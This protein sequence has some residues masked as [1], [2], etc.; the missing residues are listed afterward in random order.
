[1]LLVFLL[2]F[3]LSFMLLPESGFPSLVLSGERVLPLN[4]SMQEIPLSFSF[5]V[6]E[7]PD[8]RWAQFMLREDAIAYCEEYAKVRP[9]PHVVVHVPTSKVIYER[10]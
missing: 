8:I 6:I 1:M 10:N 4:L 9:G 7:K 3:S 5:E 2:A